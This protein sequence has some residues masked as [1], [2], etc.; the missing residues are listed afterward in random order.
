[1]SRPKII[2][3]SMGRDLRFTGKRLAQ[4]ES[5]IQANSRNVYTLY[6]TNKGIYVLHDETISADGKKE[7]WA[8][9]KI[10][11][12]LTGLL[13]WVDQ[14]HHD[15]ATMKLLLDKAGIDYYRDVQP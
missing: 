13:E 8:S 2:K 14:C 1:M 3:V 10:F 5:P 15:N 12:T 6:L 4:A 11:R 9:A 7:V